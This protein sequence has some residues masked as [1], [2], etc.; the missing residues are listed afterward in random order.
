M[1]L[2]DGYGQQELYIIR[3]FFQSCL[4]VVKLAFFSASYSAQAAFRSSSLKA[5]SSLWSSKESC[6][7]YPTIWSLKLW[8]SSARTGSCG[9]TNSEDRW[10]KHAQPLHLDKTP[11]CRQ[12]RLSMIT[13][14]IQLQ[15]QTSQ[16]RLVFVATSV[17]LKQFETFN[18]R[19]ENILIQS[20]STNRNLAAGLQHQFRELHRQR[21]NACTWKGFKRTEAF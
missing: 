15:T 10:A 1:A 11:S 9:G 6:S 19:R 2:A 3:A 5:S 12:I 16:S 7:W 8:S 4:D 18:Q 14:V 21:S 20:Q 17:Y 13:A